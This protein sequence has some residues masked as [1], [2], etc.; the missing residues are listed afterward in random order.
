[1]HTVIVEDFI[2]PRL[3]T[4]RTWKEKLNRDTKKL[5][6]LMKQMDLTNI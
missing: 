5:I 2:T 1:M 4:D 6:E 3:S